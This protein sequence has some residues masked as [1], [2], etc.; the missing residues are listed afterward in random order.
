MLTEDEFDSLSA[1]LDSTD[2]LEFF[3]QAGHDAVR[4][5][6]LSALAGVDGDLVGRVLSYVS[7]ADF[8]ALCAT[9]SNM[10]RMLDSHRILKPFLLDHM[11]LDSAYLSA[12]HPLALHTSPARHEVRIL[13][14]GITPAFRAS[15][16]MAKMQAYDITDRLLLLRRK[17]AK[18]EKKAD[19]AFAAIESHDYLIGHWAEEQKEAMLKNVAPLMLPCLSLVQ[20]HIFGTLDLVLK[21]PAPHAVQAWMRMASDLTL[22][23]SS[24]NLH[25]GPCLTAV[26]RHICLPTKIANIVNTNYDVK[27]NPVPHRPAR[28]CGSWLSI[29]RLGLT[30]ARLRT[31]LAMALARWLVEAEL[32]VSMADTNFPLLARQSQKQSTFSPTT[33]DL[34]KWPAGLNAHG[35][36]NQAIILSNVATMILHEVHPKAM[37]IVRPPCE[38]QDR[39]DAAEPHHSWWSIEDKDSEGFADVIAAWAPPPAIDQAPRKHVDMLFEALLQLTRAY[40]EHEVARP[41]TTDTLCCILLDAAAR[42]IRY[43]RQGRGRRPTRDRDRVHQ[44]QRRPREKPP[45]CRPLHRRLCAQFS[46]HRRVRPPDAVVARARGAAPTGPHPHHLGRLFSSGRLRPAER[47]ACP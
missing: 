2:C 15:D 42:L 10:G 12:Q 5:D 30:V 32:S 19:R 11:S 20:S 38:S 16:H 29:P 44:R 14:V 8:F 47:T 43:E 6:I 25:Q 1:W 39:A 18:A 31:P 21:T 41:R 34:E 33:D 13:T 3:Q 17:I 40:V 36:D 22:R 45:P 9:S 28:R 24:L 27:S 7:T 37:A 4:F 46:L 35:I 26:A 23:I